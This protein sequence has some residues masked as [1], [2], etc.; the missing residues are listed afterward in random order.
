VTVDENVNRTLD[1]VQAVKLVRVGAIRTGP[2]A[3]SGM[4]EYLTRAGFQAVEPIWS[5]SSS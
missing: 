1:A 3:F 5:P 4:A 2:S